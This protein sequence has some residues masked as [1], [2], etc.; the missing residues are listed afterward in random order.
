M[1]YIFSVCLILSII[2]PYSL[3][4]PA[5]QDNTCNILSLSGGGSFGAVEVGILQDLIDVLQ[6]ANGVVQ[7]VP[8]PLVDSTMAPLAPQIISIGNR[9]N[10][11]LSQHHFIE[12]NR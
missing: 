7:G 9:L 3:S 1:N 6:N 2:F 8:V 4:I 5:S 10:D 12:P 11:V